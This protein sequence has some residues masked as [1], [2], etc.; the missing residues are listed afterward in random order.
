MAVCHEY[1]IPHSQFESWSIDDQ[2]KALEYYAWKH[3]ICQKCGTDPSDWMGPDGIPIEPPPYQ[4][5]TTR[6]MGCAAL[7]ESRASVDDKSLAGQIIHS[8]AKVPKKIA[9]R[10]MARWQMKRST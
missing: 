4:A 7:D 1:G 9:E 2:D 3:T 10:E 5:Q 6:C 8:L